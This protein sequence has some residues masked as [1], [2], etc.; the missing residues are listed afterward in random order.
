MPRCC[1]DKRAIVLGASVLAIGVLVGAILA[2]PAQHGSGSSDTAGGRGVPDSIE[3]QTRD[4]AYPVAAQRPVA[5]G[6]PTGRG[7]VSE[8]TAEVTSLW[9]IGGRQRLLGSGIAGYLDRLAE[10]GEVALPEIEEFLKSGEDVRFR[11]ARDPRGRSG[12]YRSLRLALFETLRRIG[13][14]RAEAI[15]ADELR[16]TADPREIAKLAEVLEDLAP[17]QYRALAL[18]AAGET[19]A[20]AWEGE[21]A[22]MD[23]T[24]LFGVY[25]DYGDPR[26]AASVLQH[27]LWKDWGP[28][29]MVAL[30]ELDR[31][32]GLPLLTR[33]ARSSVEDRPEADV[34]TQRRLLALQMLTQLS[35]RNGRA[36]AVLFEQVERD[37][38]PDRLWP[39]LAAA[40][41]GTELLGIDAGGD[42]RD[43]LRTLRVG[44]Q[45]IYAGNGAEGMTPEDARVRLALID[46]LRLVAQSPEALIALDSAEASLERLLDASD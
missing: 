46:E 41:A 14:P 25:R 20:L 5:D 6:R 28:S 45:V 40:L 36:R 1:L 16:Y 24:P 43:D 12:Q 38:V 34:L 33:M 17:E 23:L 18:E 31:Q 35:P 39:S 2:R 4:L 3:T 42:G 10:L 22:G 30:A 27:N 13:G 7:R 9:E 15:L 26:E 19:L 37:R 8:A 11:P 44:N 21:V 32:A 29:A